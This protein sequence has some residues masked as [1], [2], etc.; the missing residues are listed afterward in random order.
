MT[1]PQSEVSPSVSIFSEADFDRALAGLDL[2]LQDYNWTPGDNYITAPSLVAA[3]RTK[4]VTRQ[5][6]IELLRRLKDEKVFTFWSRTIPAGYTW[7]QGWPCLRLEP[8][9]TEHLITTQDRWQRFLVAHRKSCRLKAPE[10][11]SDNKDS[12]L[13]TGTE[14]TASGAPG[15]IAGAIDGDAVRGGRPIAGHARQL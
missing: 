9:T 8:K 2:C 3:L 13:P 6:A 7:E 12:T 4:D 15:G 10:N 1:K 5:L 14:K 11:P